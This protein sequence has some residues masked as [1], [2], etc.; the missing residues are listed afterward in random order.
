M[1]TLKNAHNTGVLATGETRQRRP[2]CFRLGR[3]GGPGGSSRARFPSESRADALR[4][5]P[6]WS[7]ARLPR[8][9]I[10]DPELKLLD[11]RV[12]CMLAGSVW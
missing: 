9:V 8:V 4:L 7:Y 6:L 10:C 2:G 3:K 11:I 12:Y 5:V 1:K